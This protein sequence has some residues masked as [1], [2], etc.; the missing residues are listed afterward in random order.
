MDQELP[1]IECPECEFRFSVIWHNN[2]EAIA[3]LR[4]V[5]FCPRCGEELPE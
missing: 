2:A 5:C 4:Q 3:G 1:E